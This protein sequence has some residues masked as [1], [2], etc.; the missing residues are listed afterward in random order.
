[1]NETAIFYCYKRKFDEVYNKRLLEILEK[2]YEIKAD[3]IQ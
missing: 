1:M 3:N 2:R